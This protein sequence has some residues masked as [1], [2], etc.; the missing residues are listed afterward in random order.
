MSCRFHSLLLGLILVGCILATSIAALAGVP[1]TISYQGKLWNTSGGTP[2][3]A[4]GQYSLVFKLYNSGPPHTAPIWTSAPV[5][6]TTTGGVF[7]A[8]LAPPKSVFDNDD[9]WLQTVVEGTALSPTVKLHVVPYAVRADKSD[10]AL[11]VPDGSITASKLSSEIGT[12]RA[13]YL[14]GVRSGLPG[15]AS[16]E[17]RLDGQRPDPPVILAEPFTQAVEVIEYRTGEITRHIPGKQT[18]TSLV[19]RRMITR[20]TS[21]FE[22]AMDIWLNNE[23]RHN[24]ELILSIEG[25]AVRRWT[26]TDGW[27][28]R[29]TTRLAD[30]GVPVEEIALEFASNK[31]LLREGKGSGGTKPVGADVLRGFTSGWPEGSYAEIEIAGMPFPDYVLAGDSGFGR[32]VIVYRSG[33][34]PN[35]EFKLPGNQQ[36]DGL[37]IRQNPTADDFLY[38]WFADTYAGTFPGAQQVVVS[39]VGPTSRRPIIRQED[40]WPYSYTLRLAD[41]GLPIEEFK[42]IYDTPAQ[43]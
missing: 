28:S 23:S 17:I 4:D 43:P 25:M 3:P 39:I 11:T 8:E 13:P 34:D 15:K 32:Q 37:E 36:V 21:W 22:W 42:L 26:G 38:N 40:A 2:L 33:T 18:S 41:D 12:V 29:Y 27:V 7:T 35:V 19:L 31:A 30:D 6:V 9:L 20:D 10:L 1:Q 5:N 14:I 24:V 16:F